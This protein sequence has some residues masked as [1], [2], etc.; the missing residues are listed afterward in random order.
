MKNPVKSSEIKWRKE[1]IEEGKNAV[2]AFNISDG[3]IQF[4]NETAARI[5]ELCD[6]SKDIDE[7]A[8]IISNEYSEVSLTECKKDVII[9]LNY[10]KE[11][12]FIS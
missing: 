9:F 3:N 4:L 7:I 1:E 11:I 10:L 5:W 6:G 8:L 12:N 2:L